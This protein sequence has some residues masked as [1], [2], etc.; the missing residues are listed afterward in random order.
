MEFNDNKVKTTSQSFNN[1][2]SVKKYI[3]STNNIKHKSEYKKSNYD[4]SE[5]PKQKSNIFSNMLKSFAIVLTTVT[6]GIVGTPVL[7]SSVKA[8][9][10]ELQAYETGVYYCVS[11]SEYEE[12]LKVVLFNDFTNREEEVLDSFVYGCFEDLAPNM[13]YTFAIKKGIS[14]I[15]KKNVKTTNRYYDEYYKDYDN[16]DIDNNDDWAVIDD[17]SDGRIIREEET[18]DDVTV[19]TDYDRENTRP[20][21]SDEPE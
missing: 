11:L 15:A 19:A 21:I 7:A 13:E 18:G 1:S 17:S 8:E 4:F 9:I 2:N 6:T 5:K 10:Q 12:G 3:S 20:I 14:I 16:R